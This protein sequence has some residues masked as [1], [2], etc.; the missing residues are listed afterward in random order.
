MLNDPLVMALTTNR[1]HCSTNEMGFGGCC[2]FNNGNNVN[3][4][5]VFVQ[6]R[7]SV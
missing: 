4:N 6:E 5:L 1:S 7:V 2:E 3:I